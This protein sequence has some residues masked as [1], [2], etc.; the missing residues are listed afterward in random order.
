M[1]RAVE[2]AV[3]RSVRGA[4]VASRWNA[5]AFLLGARHG[6]SLLTGA[7]PMAAAVIIRDAYKRVPAYREFIDSH[8]GLPAR[9]RGDDARTW[10]EQVPTTSKSNYID[11]YGMVDRCWDGKLPTRGVEID[12]SAGSSGTPYQWVRSSDELAEVHRTLELLAGYML[13]HGPRTNQT[14]QLITINAFSMGAWATGVNVSAALKRMGVLK[15]CGPDVEKILA[16]LTLFG[17]TPRYTMCGYP[18]FLETV[19]DAAVEVGLDLAAFDITGFVGGEGMSE[20]L[21]SRLE[22]SYTHVWSAYGASDLD[23]G[24]AA[25]TP[26]SVWL[27]QK[28]SSDPKLAEA[29]FG[30]STRVP[31]CFQYDPA[32]Y[33]LETSEGPFGRELVAT[34]LRPTLSPRL[35]YTVGDAGGVLALR[36]ALAIARD[37]GFDPTAE[38]EID[39]VWGRPLDLPLLYIHGRADS[40]V[41]YMGANLYPEDISAGVDDGREASMALGVTPGAFCLELV[42]EDDPRP[43]VHV[44]VE[45][46]TDAADVDGATEA[47]T[48]AIRDRLTSNSADYRAALAEDP[49]AARLE[50]RWHQPGSG[51][52]AENSSRIKRRYLVTGSSAAKK[53]TDLVREL[54]AKHR[55]VLTDALRAPSAHNAQPWRLKWLRSDEGATPEPASSEPQ[56]YAL[57]YDHNDYLPFDP[58][59]RDAYLCMGAL[60]ETMSLAAARRGLAADVEEVFTR[61]SSDLHVVDITLRPQAEGEADAETAQLARFAADRHTNRATYTKQPLPDE[62][63]AALTELGCSMIDPVAASRFCAQASALSWRDRRFVTDLER[64]FSTNNRARRGMTPRGLMLAPYET[65]LLRAAF[66]AGRLPGPM[67]TAFASRDIRLLRSAPTVAVLGADSLD[68]ADLFVAGRRLLRAWS[69][70]CGSGYGYHPISVAVDRPET[71]PEIARLSG[72]PVPAAIFRVGKPTKPAGRSNRVN[73]LDV[74]S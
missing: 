47:L 46:Q 20:G 55:A 19:A 51:P 60:A 28:A 35:R 52:F 6:G 22:A 18:P 41:S 74:L 30:T 33:H 44:E 1:S 29:L 70:I 62:L 48:D 54:P 4:T 21:R 26:L 17:S 37:F 53:P 10:L 64:F 7:G 61:N 38:G 73:L 42:D 13:D 16:V 34:V 50:V 43:C 31:M 2:W 69:V 68:P 56:R 72:I 57:H 25:E 27:R 58:D 9:G 63:T 39:P 11:A 65:A 15:S 5:N 12:E 40:T 23:I 67:G 8:G 32:S 59:D 71:A 14:R 24:V 45:R 3:A 66:A 49:R 36:D